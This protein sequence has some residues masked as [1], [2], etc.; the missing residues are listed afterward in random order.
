MHREISHADQAFQQE[1]RAGLYF[2]TA[3]IGLLI[4]L[5]L[6]W[7]SVAGW[8]GPQLGLDLPTYPDGITLF[9]G[10]WRFAL[11]AALIG[12][13]R[14][15]YGA[16]WSLSEGKLGADLALGIATLAAIFIN[17][18]LVAAEVVF[19][20]LAG[21]CL[22]AV[23]FSRTQ[24]A[25]SKLVEMT[26]RVCWLLRD[27]QQIKTPVGDLKAGDRILVRPGK[28]IPVDGVVAEGRSSVDQS[29]LTGESLPVEKDVGAEVLAGTLNQHGALVIDVRRIAEHTVMGR[30][31]EVTARA[32]R[33]K[34]PLERTADRLARYFLPIVLGLALAT[35]LANLW[36][37]RATE[38]GFYQAVYP[39]LAV[40]VVAC[41]CALILATPAAIIAALGRLAGSGVLI[42]GG[43]SLERLAGVDTFAFDKTGTLTTGRLQ[44]G[45]IVPLVEGLTSDELLRVASAA[46][47]RSEHP[48]AQMIIQE[49]RQRGLEPLPVDDFQ[50]HPGAGVTARAGTDE[51]LVGNRRLLEERGIVVTPEATAALEQLDA[52]GQTALLVALNGQVQGLIGAR[53]TMRPEAA[54][55]L[56][57]LRGLGV[58]QMSLLTGDRLAAARTVAAELGISDIH[59]ERLPTQ[60]AEWIEQAG[61]QGR[62]VAMVGDGIN[63]APALARANVGLAIGG[64]DVAAEAGD[65]VLLRE[66]LQPLPFLVRLSRKTVAIIRQNI[67][68]FAFGVNLVG[69]VLTAWIMPS[70]SDEARHASPIWAAIYHQIGSLAVLLNAM[71]LLGFERGRDFALIRGLRSA[72]Q[73]ADRLVERLNF[74][75]FAHWLFDHWRPVFGATALVVIVSYLLSGLTIVQPDQIGIVRRFGRP[76]EADLQPGLHLRLPWPWEKVTKLEPE[77]LRSVEVGFRGTGPVGGDSTWGALHSEGI[78][79]QDEESLMMTGDGNLVEVQARVFYT[80]TEPRTYLFGV[81]RPEEVLRSLTESVLRDV[82]AERPFLSLL[83]QGREEF[84]K[85]VTTRLRKRCDQDYDLGIALQSVAFQDLHPPQ[86]VVEAYYAVTRALSQREQMIVEARRD[87]ETGIA[88]E[89]VAEQRL[90]AGAQADYEATTAKTKADRDA[91][92][93]LVGAQRT[94]WLDGLAVPTPMSPQPFGLTASLLMLESRRSDPELPERLTELRLHVEAAEQMLGGRAKVLRDPRLKGQLHVMPELLKL[95][96]PLMGRDP[97]VRPPRE[98]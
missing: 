18:P 93:S 83:A 80:V 16:L 63:D 46:E 81:A 85:E 36:W 73:S 92:L 90:R 72:S 78:L 74:H 65:I 14:V 58:Q 70:W 15:L 71:R 21:E 4:L 32:L 64:I 5:D 12:A 47:Q 69:I 26:P 59:A 40:L 54:A 10:K 52:A 35:F 44:P 84:Q 27:G 43:A 17:Q 31:I 30:V 61:R 57:E 86:K 79:R 11:F 8:L 7:T 82:I 23:T 56:A 95:R 42:K 91:F 77:R 68:I 34:A 48:L 1:S 9:G 50:A 6:L 76:L 96:L 75:D 87:S 37:F 20:G 94:G 41:P 98:P 49:A 45:D 25:I 28:R 33:D 19:I 60:K 53:D 66:P 38:G 55:V 13:A 3:L 22:E 24:R 67:L 51:L 29:A 2:L 39:A 97:E 62:K 89:Q 88:R